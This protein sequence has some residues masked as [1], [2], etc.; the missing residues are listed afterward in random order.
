MVKIITLFLQQKERFM[1]QIFLETLPLFQSIPEQ[2]LPMVLQALSM[3]KRE[4]EKDAYIL[5]AGEKAGQVGILISGS[6]NIIQEDF[7][8]NRS[9]LAKAEKGELFGES[10]ACAGET[11]LPVSVVAA[12]RCCVAFLE[13]YRLFEPNG[14]HIPYSA[15]L[16]ANMLRI[17]AQK[18]IML[19]QKIQ[20]TSQRTTRQKLLS[21]LSSQAQRSNSDTFTIP[22]D[23]QELADYLSVDRS[24]MS[25]E[26]GRLRDEGIIRFYKNRFMLLK[27]DRYSG[28]N[29]GETV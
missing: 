17:Q 11:V 14:T 3:K 12:E 10:F 18:N 1:Q 5:T 2:D 6:A 23:R 19:T 24:A 4:Y 20:H 8:G 16:S 28:I 13:Y 22:F 21:Y 26:L 7:W 15:T 27:Q 9:I 29:T 25:K